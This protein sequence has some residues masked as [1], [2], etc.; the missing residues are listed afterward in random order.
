MGL[1]S[2]FDQMPRKKMSEAVYWTV[3]GCAALDEAGAISTA[4][5]IA[6]RDSGRR[7]S[8]WRDDLRVIG[9]ASFERGL[10]ECVTV[11]VFTVPDSVGSLFRDYFERRDK[12]LVT[13]AAVLDVQESVIRYLQGLQS[14]E[15][16]TSLLCLRRNADGSKTEWRVSVRGE[17]RRRVVLV[18]RG[19]GQELRFAGSDPWKDFRAAG[20]ETVSGTM[21]ARARG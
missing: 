20:F 10:Y 1:A 15:L 3:D 4:R 18:V 8:F 6:S 5:G 21:G 2:A 16:D 7:V 13:D 12:V 17:D 9:F 19:G 14:E 11:Q